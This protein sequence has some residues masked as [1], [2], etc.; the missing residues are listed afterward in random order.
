[1]ERE[2]A[3]VIASGCGYSLEH[4]GGVDDGDAV[5]LLEV[6]K[7]RIAGD[8]DIGVGRNGAGD[9]I[10]SSSGSAITVGETAATG[11]ISIVAR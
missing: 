9:G 2:A 1:L 8:D 6:Q 10:A 7:M 5:E 3:G 4:L 11:T